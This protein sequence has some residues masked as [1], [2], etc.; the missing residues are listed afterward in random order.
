MHWYKLQSGIPAL[1]R[2]RNS[3]VLFF[4]QDC[5]KKEKL[6]W[7]VKYVFADRKFYLCRYSLR[8]FT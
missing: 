8:A 7:T 5:S 2:A 4:N 1:L 6:L 3:I